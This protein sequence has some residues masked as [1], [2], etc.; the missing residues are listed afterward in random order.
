MPEWPPSGLSPAVSSE[1]MPINAA[2]AGSHRLLF[3][4]DIPRTHTGRA[5]LCICN[6]NRCWPDTDNTLH[7]LGPSPCKAT[8]DRALLTV[9]EVKRRITA[10]LLVGPP[11]GSL[12]LGPLKKVRQTGR[13]SIP[14]RLSASPNWLG[15]IDCS[16]ITPAKEGFVLVARVP[17]RHNTLFDVVRKFLAQ[18]LLCLVTPTAASFSVVRLPWR[19]PTVLQC[20]QSQRHVP[21]RPS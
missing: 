9:P 11:C 5:P 18:H 20:N 13:G 2:V 14:A 4:E 21:H 7:C 19:T 6:S 15:L 12:R 8:Q 1:A 17:L 16:P 3:S 10:A